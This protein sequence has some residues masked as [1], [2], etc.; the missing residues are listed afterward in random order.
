M[1]D[2]LNRTHIAPNIFGQPD[3]SM[4]LDQRLKKGSAKINL[5]ELC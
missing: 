5:E 3:R 1:F 2:E 4:M